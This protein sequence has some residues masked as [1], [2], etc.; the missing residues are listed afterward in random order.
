MN[1]TP[2]EAG[3]AQPDEPSQ[4]QHD[5][6]LPLLRHLR[7]HSQQQ[8]EHGR[9]DDRGDA[10]GE[11]QAEPTDRGDAE[12]H[13]HGEKVHPRAARHDLVRHRYGKHQPWGTS[14]PHVMTYTR[15]RGPEVLRDR[16]R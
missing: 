9:A 7:R 4:A 5:G 12:H 15:A 13:Q 10:P 3:P 14:F 11:E 1:G 6:A 8:S 2:E 16:C